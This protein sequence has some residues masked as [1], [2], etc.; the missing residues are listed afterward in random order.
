MQMTN[1]RQ[2]K[3]AS[4]AFAAT[5]AIAAQEPSALPPATDPSA[6]VPK[7]LWAIRRS[8]ACP[9]DAELTRNAG[10]QKCVFRARVS[11]PVWLMTLVGP[12]QNVIQNN[13]SQI[14]G[15]RNR[16]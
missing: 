10:T 11:I 14:A 8:N 4:T 1:V 6:G 3:P 9:L 12:M 15:K 13:I 5:H 2:A 7:A 16:D